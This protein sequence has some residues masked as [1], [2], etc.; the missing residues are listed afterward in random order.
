MERYDGQDLLADV[1]EDTEDAPLP[2]ERRSAVDGRVMALWPARDDPRWQV[3]A[4][5]VFPVKDEGA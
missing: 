4:F 1:F 5:G 2:Q 3:T